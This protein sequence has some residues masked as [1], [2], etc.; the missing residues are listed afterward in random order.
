MQNP[1]R[2]PHGERTHSTSDWISRLQE[3]TKVSELSPLAQRL[4][5]SL[6]LTA[7]YR[8]AR[9]DPLAELTSRLGSMTVAVKT[10]E[11]VETLASSWPEPLQVRRCCCLIASHDE[12]TIG[13]ALEAVV[14]GNRCEHDLQLADLVGPAGCERL[15][16][17]ATGLVTAELA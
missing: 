7:V 5:F 8:K 6:R 1:R 9:R 14:A 15:W 16:Q 13:R 4:V 11:L 12:V 10:L 17:A 2:M 3:P